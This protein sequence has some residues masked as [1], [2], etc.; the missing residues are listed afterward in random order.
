MLNTDRSSFHTS[1]LLGRTKRVTRVAPESYKRER[2][3]E[4]ERCILVARCRNGGRV[5]VIS[6]FGACILHGMICVGAM[7]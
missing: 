4:R 3:R 7:L 6:Y 5:F 1:Q 2:E